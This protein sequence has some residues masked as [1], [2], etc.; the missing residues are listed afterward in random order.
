[1]QLAVNGLRLLGPRFGVGRYV[2]YLLR[3]WRDQA[4]PFERIVVYTPGPLDE[5]IGLPTEA[6]LRVVPTRG[7]HG[8]WEQVVL[9][10]LVSRRDVLFCPSY[11]APVL[12]GGRIVL[13]HLGSYE[14]IP[15]A[16]PLLERWRSRL[17]YQLSAHRAARVITVSESSRRDILRFYRVR[18][19]KVTVIPLGVDP[20]FRPLADPG[21]LADTRRRY[22]G[23]DTPFILFVGKL[24]R[25]RHIPEL[26]AAF[27][28][29]ERTHG[30]PHSLVLIGANTGGAD[31]GHLAERHGVNGRVVHCAFETHEA[32]IAAYNAADLFVYP[33]AYEGFGIPVL[34]AMACGVPTIALRNTS[35][36]EFAAGA[37]YLAPD[38]SEA[39]LYEAMERVLFS[40]D[41]RATLRQAGPA[42]ARHYSWDSI[43]R[44][45]MDVLSEVAAS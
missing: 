20:S 10:R 12:G 32:L 26:I 18:P 41:L 38:G 14:A 30:L 33:S 22:L 43:A 11:V 45:T 6:E 25:R 37:A 4:H 1:M 27:A 24:S 17:L 15:A 16:F 23:S 19:D 36:L 31:V 9:P 44:R 7:P 40:D 28:R 13:T 34:E 5:P 39:A 8:Y 42:R 3:C 21:L 29:L 2:E 35:F